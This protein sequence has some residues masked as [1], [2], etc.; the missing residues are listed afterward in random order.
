MNWLWREFLF[1]LDTVPAFLAQPVWFVFL[2]S[3]L[4]KYAICKPHCH[5]QPPCP[6]KPGNYLLFGKTANSKCELR[7]PRSAISW[8]FVCCFSRIIRH[9]VLKPRGASLHEI[10]HFLSDLLYEVTLRLSPSC[11]ELELAVFQRIKYLTVISLSSVQHRKKRN[12]FQ[13][14]Q[15]LWQFE[16]MYRYPLN[17]KHLLIDFSY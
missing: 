12:N 17:P 9:L 11:P 6:S 16:E 15:N 7:S 4:F 13:H 14:P 5:V 3:P 2:V 1:L 10:W 8:S